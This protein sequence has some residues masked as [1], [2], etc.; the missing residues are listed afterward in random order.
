MTKIALPLTSAQVERARS[1]T[2]N[3]LRNAIL[4]APDNG[5]AYRIAELAATLDALDRIQ[6]TTADVTTDNASSA[7]DE[8][9]AKVAGI[10]T[11]FTVAEQ[12]RAA[13]DD[14]FAQKLNKRRNEREAGEATGRG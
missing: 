2:L 8:Q 11:G 12:K 9:P 6:P 14:A 3:L 7:D 10:P 13:T 4:E 1:K 5:E